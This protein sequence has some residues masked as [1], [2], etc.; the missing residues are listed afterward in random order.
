MV[1]PSSFVNLRAQGYAQR[2]LRIK[3]MEPRASATIEPGS[4]T[5]AGN[6]VCPFEPYET[7]LATIADS[8]IVVGRTNVNTIARRA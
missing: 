5:I 7:P 2:R 1:I 8:E 3:T 4:G 6:T